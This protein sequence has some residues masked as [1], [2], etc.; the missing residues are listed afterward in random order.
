MWIGISWPDLITFWS[1]GMHD[2]IEMMHVYN[3]GACIRPT[4]T[5]CKNRKIE[6]NQHRRESADAGALLSNGS[7]CK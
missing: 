5:T 4:M 1:V 6:S 7:H 2:A 3:T